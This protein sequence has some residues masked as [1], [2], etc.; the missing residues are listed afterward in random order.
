MKNNNK[1]KGLEDKI[2]SEIK[3]GR[4]KL[5]S[6]YV[7]LAKK[8]GLNSGIIL[9]VILSILFFSLVLFYMRTTDSLEYLSFGKAGILAF[10]ESFPYLLVV[11]LILLLFATGYLITKTEWSYKKPF[12]YFALGILTL[13]LIVGSAAAYSGVT[14]SIEEQAF[15]NRVPG[16]FLKPLIGRGIESRGRGIA[17]K[18]YEINDNYLILETP[19]GFEKVSLLELDCDN[20][21]SHRFSEAGCQ[22]PF[23]IDQFII[24]VGKKEDSVF[25]AEKIHVVGEKG[26]PPMIRRG[27]HRQ[28]VSFSR[29]YSTITPPLPS[30]LLNFDEQTNECIKECF[31]NRIH[32]RECFDK[33]IE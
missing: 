24:A 1:S 27:I 4:V 29:N 11:S 2:M 13:V 31:K 15:K 12:K 21:D 10:L 33:C 19:R 23:T 16:M 3:S 6:K 9:T 8:L 17:G 25:V 32:P 18:I 26:F 22:D 30:H 20:S 7:F 28:F 5:R 14:E